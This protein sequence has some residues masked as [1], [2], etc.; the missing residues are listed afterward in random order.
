MN[1]VVNKQLIKMFKDKFIIF[2]LFRYLDYANSLLYHSS[3]FKVDFGHGRDLNGNLY[4]SGP[5]FNFDNNENQNGFNFLKKIGFDVD[6]DKFICLT[7]R[8]DGYK[9]KVMTHNFMDPEYW[10][11][12][13]FRDANIKNYYDVSR[14]LLDKGYWVIRMG[15]FTNNKMTINHNKFLDY[16]FSTYRDDFLDIWLMANCFF[17]IS[18]STGIDEVAKMFRKPIVFTDMSFYHL[19]N[20]NLHSITCFKKMIYSKSKKLISLKEM[21]KNNYMEFSRTEHFQENGIELIDNSHEEIV[22]TVLEMEKNL[23]NELN[24]SKET[25]GLNEKFLKIYKSWKNY[26]KY[27]GF[28]H[29]KASIST[30]FLSQNKDWFLS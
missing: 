15:K 22:E 26:E 29:P 13:N 21:I 4:F 19:P 6:K 20:L 9:K 5:N 8:D 17:S 18:N 11:Y 30:S 27:H 16:S 23:T 14:E 2:F 12:H 1:H 7:I 24:Q 28:I 10:K 3:D 25:L